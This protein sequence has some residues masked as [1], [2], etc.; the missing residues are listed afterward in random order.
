MR[1]LLYH[2]SQEKPQIIFLHVGENYISVD[3]QNGVHVTREIISLA[4]ELVIQS[5]CKRLYVGELLF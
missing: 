1:P 3:L 2:V 4:Q 5:F